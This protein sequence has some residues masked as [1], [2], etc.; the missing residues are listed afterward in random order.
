MRYDIA[1][2]GSGPAGLSA[3]INAKIRNKT[4]IMFG[5]DNL[6]N[7]L[8]KAPSVDNYLGFYD[9]SGDELKDKFKSHIDSMDIS[10]ENKRINN[11]YAMGEYFTI[12]SG[13]DMYEAT[14]VILAT[15]VEYTRPIKGEEEFLGR[16]VGY[17][18]TCDAPLY[19]NKKVAVIGYNEESKEEANFLSEL[20]SKTYFI[21]MYKKDN[22]MRSS[23]N[24]DDSIEVIHDRPVQIDGDKLV[25]KVSFK[26]K[27]IEVDGV[28]V[29]K[30]STSPSALV[31]GIEIDGIHIK[32]DN[33][34]KTSIDGCFA[35]GDCVGKPYSYIKA[36]GQGQI[37][38]LN[39]V[40][41]LDKLKRA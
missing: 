8:V 15:G 9:I 24:L 35:A 13:N 27:H 14:T 6:S 17:C 12:M 16:G 38:A 21:P 1:I 33:N 2:I 18:A 32:V 22:L 10:I 5:N 23:D 29:I 20:T 37:A 4:I 7:K 41:Y 11:I 25:N 26:E 30:D 28:F 36:A 19:R 40:Y 34:M 39:A 3:A 31:P